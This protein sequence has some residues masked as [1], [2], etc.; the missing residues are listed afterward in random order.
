VRARIAPD[1][2]QRTG[3]FFERRSWVE[4]IM[5]M[6]VSVHA[7]GA[8]VRDSDVADA[9]TALFADLR[10]LEDVFSTYRPGSEV[11]RLQRGELTLAECSADVQEVHRL[12]RVA[13]ALTDGAFDAWS[14]VPDR[15]GVFDPTGLVKS[16][17][18][19]RAARRLDAV[20]HVAFAVGAGGDV[21]ITPGAQGREWIIG[22]EDPRDR[23]RLV[24]TAPVHDGAV[25]TSGI[26]ARGLHIVD[27][28]SGERAAEVLSATVI[29][30]SLL[31]ADVFATA[32]VALGREAVEWVGGLHGTSGLLVLA[33]GRLHRWQNAP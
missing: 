20:G 22:I 33:D 6:P 27:P 18:V 31:W 7:R 13:L 2:G 30:P 25:A 9:V 29:G 23:E 4:H 26:A 32:A 11:S 21:L 12:C 16:W 5:G 1:A 3:D 28:R 14:A 8:G 10:A 17:A 24:A 19:G 15:P